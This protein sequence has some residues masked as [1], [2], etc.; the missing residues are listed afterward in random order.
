VDEEI[1][2]NCINWWCYFIYR[3]TTLSF[4][5]VDRVHAHFNPLV[6]HI[7]FVLG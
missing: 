4:W 7:I 5:I 2:F 6:F 1:I 3:S